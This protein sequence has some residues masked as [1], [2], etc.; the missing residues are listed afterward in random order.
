MI[1]DEPKIEPLFQVLGRRHTRHSSSYKTKGPAFAGEDILIYF[2][3]DYRYLG[4]YLTG[5]RFANAKHSSDT[6][7]PPRNTWPTTPV[8]HVRS[9]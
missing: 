7:H 3:K 8:W 6:D 5:W 1:F 2:I 4:E 9:D